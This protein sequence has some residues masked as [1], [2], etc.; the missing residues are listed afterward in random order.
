MNFQEQLEVMADE[1]LK[2]IGEYKYYTPKDMENAT[3]VFQEVFIA[4]MYDNNKDKLPFDKLC[5]MAEEAGK[6]MHQTVLL[7]TGIDLKKVKPDESDLL[8]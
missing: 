8:C 4:K 1:S 5:L 2:T 7:F 6:S 3:L